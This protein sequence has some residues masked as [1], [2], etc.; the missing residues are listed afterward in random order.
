MITATPCLLTYHHDPGV[1]DQSCLLKA[2]SADYAK[3]LSPDT[4]AS[5][6]PCNPDAP[7]RRPGPTPAKTKPP[8][9]PTS[10]HGA[11]HHAGPHDQNRPIMRSAG[12][13][14][15]RAYGLPSGVNNV[16]IINKAITAGR[17]TAI[18]VKERLGF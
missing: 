3:A 1:S 15:R 13:R 14:A 4:R 8:S 18:I 12:P 2:P 10:D 9:Q 11:R 6:S 16:L 7:T 5:S 17:V